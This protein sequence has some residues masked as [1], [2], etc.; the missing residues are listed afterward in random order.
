MIL[1]VEARFLHYGDCCVNCEL[2]VFVAIFNFFSHLTLDGFVVV[3]DRLGVSLNSVF[4][5]ISCSTFMQVWHES[6]GSMSTYG[7]ITA[8]PFSGHFFQVHLGQPVPR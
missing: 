4:F 7:T 6:Y 3:Y 5:V 8:D 1:L 2:C